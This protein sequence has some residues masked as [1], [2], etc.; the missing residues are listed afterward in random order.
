MDAPSLI[1]LAAVVAIA[2]LVVPRLVLESARRASDG[3]AH[4]FVPP[5]RALG[6]PRGVQEGDD[7][8]GWQSPAEVS[9]A[10]AAAIDERALDRPVVVDIDGPD[11]AWYASD[12]TI[13]EL[14]AG[15]DVVVP[16]GR[17]TRD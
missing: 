13:V 4:L 9:R 7:P 17:V 2:V 11:P 15:G 16:V 8:W 1:T 3:I 14:G 5:D 12:A 6:W 10:Q